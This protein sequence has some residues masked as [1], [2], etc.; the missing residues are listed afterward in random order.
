M[1]SNDAN[2]GN[3]KTYCIL[4][5]V[6][7]LWLVGMTQMPQDEDVKFHVNQGIIL[8]IAGVVADAIAGI[9]LFIPIIGQLLMTVV[10]L[11]WLG[12]AIMGIINAN[13]GVQKELPVIG[14]F[15][16]YK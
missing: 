2:S 15:R 3:K 7:I 8:T 6:F 1:S 9:F 4:S 10:S 5:Y 14:K 12:L 11:G 13:N 16:I